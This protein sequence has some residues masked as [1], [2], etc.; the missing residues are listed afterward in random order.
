[1][2][3]EFAPPMYSLRNGLRLKGECKC[4]KKSVSRR[5]VP[6]LT[7]PLRPTTIIRELLQESSS[8]ESLVIRVTK[9]QPSHLAI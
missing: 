5:I 3:K 7:V 9:K 6:R 1:M 8:F 4:I 2:I